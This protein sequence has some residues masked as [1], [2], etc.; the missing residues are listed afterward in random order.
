MEKKSVS[1]DRQTHWDTVIQPNACDYQ[2]LNIRAGLPH[3][4]FKP[5]LTPR[6]RAGG[7]S[8]N[9]HAAF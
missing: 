7:A 6:F 4:Y 1:I 3:A 5:L 8:G 9:K 2:K